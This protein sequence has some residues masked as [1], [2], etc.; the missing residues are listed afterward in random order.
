MGASFEEAPTM[1]HG[2]SGIFISNQAKIGKRVVILQQVTIGSNTI[3]GSRHFGSPTIEDDV[4]IG[5]GAKIIGKITIGHNSRIGAGVTVVED[6]PPNSVVV[7][8]PI[9]II[10]KEKLLNNQWVGLAPATK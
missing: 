10:T 6:V 5:A 8:A 3:A 7:S 9:R 1:P 2:F 4:F